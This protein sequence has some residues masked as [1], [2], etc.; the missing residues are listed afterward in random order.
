[1]KPVQRAAKIRHTIQQLHNGYQIGFAGQPRLTR[2][3]G[4]LD[5]W[6]AQLKALSTQVKVLPPQ[7]RKELT[8]LIKQR[9]SLYRKEAE[10]VRNAQELNV[11]SQVAYGHIEWANLHSDRYQRH[12]AG[13]AR[14]TRDGSLLSEL[15]VEAQVWLQQAKDHLEANRAE[16]DDSALTDLESRIE[17]MSQSEEM[18]HSELKSITEVQQEQGSPQERADLYAFL[19]NQ[20]FQLYRAH[21]SGHS[22]S[23]R[24]LATLERCNSQLDLI[25]SLM[26]TV[27]DGSKSKLED[28][29][30]AQKNFDIVQQ[31]LS[32][33]QDEERQIDLAQTQLDYNGWVKGLGEAAQK[34]YQDYSD[35][36]A[37]KPRSGCDPALLLQLC[38][39]LYD[40]TIQLRPFV[41]YSPEAEERGLLLL[42][43]DQLRLYH[44]EFGLVTEAVKTQDE[45]RH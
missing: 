44:R 13:Q 14:N 21:F 2:S 11:V 17:R 10:A 5:A 19:A 32:G 27:L 39:R 8:D 30:R 26:K 37:N 41:E 18:Y 34:V 36:F 45:V 1:M 33:Y 22:R 40:I 25:A 9:I 3:A 15:T 23:S 12:F 20:C 31:N 35:N 28:F 43:L 16:L 4:Q 38:D 29:D 42:M 6:M 7:F 24:R